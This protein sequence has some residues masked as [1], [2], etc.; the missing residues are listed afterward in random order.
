MFVDTSRRE[1]WSFHKSHKSGQG[2]IFPRAMSLA[3]LASRQS[4]STNG[5]TLYYHGLISLPLICLE[6]D[7]NSGDMCQVGRE[8]RLP[9][10]K[11]ALLHAQTKYLPPDSSLPDVSLEF[12]SKLQKV[13]WGKKAG[14]GL[15][16]LS[17]SFGSIQLGWAPHSLM[18]WNP[19]V[20]SCSKVTD[21]N[22]SLF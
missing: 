22:F 2:L 18:N 8:L 16:V 21:S 11:L 3:S 9:F 5:R 6:F 7:L 17:G 13:T 15:D 19:T 10:K 14:G 12:H 1:F 4:M 20:K